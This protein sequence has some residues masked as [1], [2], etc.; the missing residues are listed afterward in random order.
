[1]RSVNS[2]LNLMKGVLG[3]VPTAIR[4]LDNL[5]CLLFF[6]LHV[7]PLN[8]SKIKDRLLKSRNC[9]I[10]VSFFIPWAASVEGFEFDL[11]FFIASRSLA[12]TGKF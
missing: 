11:T 1:M 5:K 6:W 8:F 7:I 12:V 4:Y 9:V 3:Q 10:Q 2:S